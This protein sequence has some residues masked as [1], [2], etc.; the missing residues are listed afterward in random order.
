MSVS[1]RPTNTTYLHTPP[2]C[3]LPDT[4]NMRLQYTHANYIALE[5]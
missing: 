4:L 2:A 1:E 3:S 5:I